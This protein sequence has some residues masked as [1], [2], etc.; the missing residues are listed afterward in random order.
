[1]S[2]C[3]HQSIQLVLCILVASRYQVLPS[4]FLVGSHVQS[5]LAAL[6]LVHYVPLPLFCFF[7]MFSQPTHCCTKPFDL[8][9]LRGSSCHV[10][11]GIIQPL[12]TA[13][14]SFQFAVFYKHSA[15]KLFV[16]SNPKVHG[17]VL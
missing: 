5:F 8:C 17:V 4:F 2:F 15:P 3:C 9:L 6:A 14:N 16:S 10:F 12:T 1:M 13:T 11:H 7:W